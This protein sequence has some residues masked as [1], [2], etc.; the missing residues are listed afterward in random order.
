VEKFWSKDKG[1]LADYVNGDSKD[2]S[3]RPNQIIATSLPYSPL[4][5]GKRKVVLDYVKQDLLTPRGMRTLS[6]NHPDYQGVYSGDQT[7]RDKAYHQGTIWPWLFGHFAEGFLK[8][9]GKSGLSLIK[10]IYENFEETMLEHGVGSISEI[11]E[12]D[13]PHRPEGAISQAWSVSELLRVKR[14]IDKIENE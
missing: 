8:V 14:L 5:E 11:Y 13:P 7:T 3:M 9:H 1:Y 4:S 12:A 6:P 2:W 10:S